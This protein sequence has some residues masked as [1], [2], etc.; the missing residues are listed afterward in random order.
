MGLRQVLHAPVLATA[1]G[2]TALS[3]PAFA[4]NYDTPYPAPEW[5]EDEATGRLPP[6][7]ANGIDP[8]ARAEWVNECRRRVASSGN[9]LG[10]AVV[11]GVIGGLAG[12]RIAG[13][14]NR[15]VGTVAGA[16]V[17]AVAGGAIDQA[18]SRS[19]A[20]DDC[21]AYYDDYY[22]RYAQSGYGQ[23]GYGQSG[24]GYAPQTVMVPVTVTPGGPQCTE[25]YETVYDD[26][27]VRRRVI[28]RAVPRRVYTV[29]DKRVR[30]VPD[31]RV[32]TR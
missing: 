15:T 8:R 32:R 10:G 13:R 11:G 9:G 31:K 4:Q 27:P 1:L 7:V 20:S 18:Q 21:E 26:V 2:L 5:R 22:T 16:A 14:G 23:S 24:Y 28:R 3:A 25:T 17:G 30:I 12:N 6:A 19:R 29:P